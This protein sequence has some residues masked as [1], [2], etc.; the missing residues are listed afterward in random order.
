LFQKQTKNQEKNL[1]K[2]LELTQERKTV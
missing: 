2:E 1:T